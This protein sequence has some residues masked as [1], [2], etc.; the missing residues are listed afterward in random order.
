M[1]LDVQ[2]LQA[3]DPAAVAGLWRQCRDAAVKASFRTGGREFVD[4]VAQEMVMVVLNAFLPNYEPGREIGP[5]LY[6]MARRMGLRFYRKHSSEVLFTTLAASTP[7]GMV[8]FDQLIPD[9][10]GEDTESNILKAEATKSALDARARLIARMRAVEAM[11][12]DMPA[13][14]AEEQSPSAAG[15]GQG[16]AP[17]RA[18]TPLIDL[19]KAERRAQLAARPAVVKL[20]A[21]RMRL[22][23]TQP[24]FSKILGMQENYVRILEG[25]LIVGQPKELLEAAEGIVASDRL[26]GAEFCTMIQ[27]LNRWCLQ[28]GLAEDDHMQ[29]GRMLDIHRTTLYR[30]R[31]EKTR[32]DAASIMRIALIVEELAKMDR[33]PA[34]YDVHG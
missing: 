19:A 1:E 31:N 12:S 32:P 16:R 5:Y 29:L 15:K 2:A 28:L 17:R 22:G 10:E 30:W 23:Y 27:L 24:Q 11:A 7:D 4:D 13:A 6:E 25:G 8:D 18:R 21:L 14:G 26:E 3:R 9:Q 34:E 20:R 33:S